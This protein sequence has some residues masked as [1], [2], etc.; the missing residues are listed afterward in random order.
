MATC[1]QKTW[2]A[3]LNEKTKSQLRTVRCC[4]GMVVGNDHRAVQL[5]PDNAIAAAHFLRA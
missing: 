4:A 5:P 1:N 3:V 2:E